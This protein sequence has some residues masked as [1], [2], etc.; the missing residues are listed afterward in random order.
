MTGLIGSRIHQKLRA[1]VKPRGFA[2]VALAVKMCV[3]G[4][5]ATGGK[6]GGKA[7]TELGVPGGQ[8]R[9][10]HVQEDTKG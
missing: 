10:E 4:E 3:G 7:L 2:K 9:Q 8:G 6:A 1:F 5:V